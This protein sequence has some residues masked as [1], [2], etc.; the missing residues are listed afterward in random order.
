MA[1]SLMLAKNVLEVAL[2]EEDF[3]HKPAGW[4]DNYEL[5]GEK[6][7]VAEVAEVVDAD[8]LPLSVACQKF[9]KF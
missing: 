6:I 3:R 9:C 2:S 8:W 1:S 4:C 7:L 5:I